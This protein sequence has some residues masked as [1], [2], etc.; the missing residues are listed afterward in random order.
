M[1]ID[2]ET[3]ERVSLTALVDT[4]SYLM[5]KQLVRGSKKHGVRA[6]QQDILSKAIR[7]LYISNNRLE[8]ALKR[9]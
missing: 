4:E 8:K 9:G 6:T 3:P 5:L 1:V 2:V 7:H